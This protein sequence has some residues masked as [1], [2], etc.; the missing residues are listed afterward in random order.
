MTLPDTDDWPARRLLLFLINRVVDDILDPKITRPELEV[1][2]DGLALHTQEG[3]LHEFTM[4][5]LER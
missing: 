3:I 1:L 4:Q 5:R 2:W